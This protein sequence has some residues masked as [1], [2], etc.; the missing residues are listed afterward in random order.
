MDK[1]ITKNIAFRLVFPVIFGLLAYL[2]ML[3]VFDNVA[4][5]LNSFF[6]KEVAFFVLLSFAVFE[7]LLFVFSLFEKH[8]VLKDMPNLRL[9]LFVL[10]TIIISFLVV[11]FMVSCYFIFIEKTKVYQTELLVFNFIML[12]ASLLYLTV[13]YSTALIAKQAGKAISLEI[14]EKE[15]IDRRLKLLQ[16]K[17]HPEIL[18]ESLEILIDLIHEDEKHAEDFIGLLSAFYRNIIDERHSETVA[19]NKEISAAEHL[20]VLL[21]KRY[22]G[23]IKLQKLVSKNIDY[24]IMPG[25]V[26]QLV[27]RAVQKNIISENIP[28]IIELKTE[29]QYLMFSYICH[30]RLTDSFGTYENLDGIIEKYELFSER[31][32]EETKK[33]DGYLIQIP[34]PT[35]ENV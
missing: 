20:I 27:F 8:R 35:L 16:S 19:L 18:Y 23:Q 22:K 13:F 4:L 34:L 2:V 3:M 33:Q 10:A 14:L 7:S 21:N 28:L 12:F 17:L 5:I 11:S 26:Q 9:A 29:N 25:V 30:E 15:N 31:K 1:Q 32:I 24:Q 6:S